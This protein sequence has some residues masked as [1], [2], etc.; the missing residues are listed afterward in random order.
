MAVSKKQYEPALVS[1][2]NSVLLEI[3]HL[4]QAYSSG[5][6]VVGGSVPGLI[7]RNATALQHLLFHVDI[8]LDQNKIPEKDYSSIKILLIKRGYQLEEQP[9]SFSREVDIEGRIIK[10][11]VDF[12]AGEYGG[13]SNKHR[14]Q[15]IQDL[16]P[17]KARACDLAFTQTISVQIIGELPQGGKDQAY[18]QVA[19]IVP[20]LMMKAQAIDG[21]LK[22]KDAYDIY[23]CLRYYPG[24]HQA[25]V[26]A[27]KSFPKNKLIDEGLNILRDKFASPDH[28]GPVFT[29]DFLEEKDQE[30]REMIKRDAYER[31]RALLE[32]MGIFDTE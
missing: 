9:F 2:A 25:L 16:H 12:L 5:F 13:T 32:S 7:L 15:S 20:F 23:Y 30:A 11:R 10:V 4:L 14:T 31:I 17:R 3:A 27:F 6:V 24:G 8:A 19:S 22:E 29:A 18:I 1:A 21:R 26:D 28:I